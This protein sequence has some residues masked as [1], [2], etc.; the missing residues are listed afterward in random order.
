MS[1]TEIKIRKTYTE[2]RLKAIV[3]VVLSDCIAIHEIKVIQGGDR[4]FVAMPCRRDSDGNYRDI[5]HPIGQPARRALE[6]A[7]INAYR[8]CVSGQEIYETDT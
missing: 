6:D 1:I 5:I 8:T 2:G 7:V 3:S 4:L